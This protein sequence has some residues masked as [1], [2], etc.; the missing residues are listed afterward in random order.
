MNKKIL[1]FVCFA[2]IS[3]TVFGQYNNRSRRG[4]D[5]LRRT[6]S[7]ATQNQP[8][9]EAQKERFAK[10]LEER[11]EELITNFL[12]TLK[13]D[14]FQKEI[15]K[16]TLNDYFEKK[17]EF[18]KFPFASTRE[19][20]DAEKLFNEAHFAELKTIIS[21]ADMVKV[22]DFITGKFSESDAKKN[23]KKKKKK[24]KKKKDN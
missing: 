3:I 15:I 14:E 19:R 21:E 22:N 2:M 10:K 17:N 8:P 24:K 12:S 18:Y 13:A 5:P 6:Q 16:Q 1:L 9:S 20:E 7:A 11:K 23:I 4:I